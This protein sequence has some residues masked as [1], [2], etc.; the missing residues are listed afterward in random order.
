VV[1]TGLQADVRPFFDGVKLSVAP[2]RWGA[3]VKGKINQSM[4][5]GVPVVTT[6][7]GAEGMRLTDREEILIADDPQ[8]FAR[9]MIELYESEELWTRISEK[10]LAKTR[11]MYSTEAARAS[12]SQLLGEEHL[13]SFSSPGPSEVKVTSRGSSAGYLQAGLA[14]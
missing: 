3:G 8:S 6:S 14:K 9:A 2:L 12:L 7:V 4:G 1:V 10:G 13:Q 5:Y 11:A